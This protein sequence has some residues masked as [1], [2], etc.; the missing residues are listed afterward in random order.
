LASEG[1]RVAI[2]ARIPDGTYG[3]VQQWVIGLAGALSRLPD[4]DEVYLFLVRRGRHDWLDPYLEGRCRALVVADRSSGT[5]RLTRLRRCLA[6]ALPTVAARWRHVRDYIAARRST[7]EVARSDGVI[8]AAGVD[9]VHFTFQD[10]FI[11]D[12]PSLYQPWD[13]Q[14]RHL[15]TFFSAAER[16]RREITYRAFSEQARVV[17]APTTWIK[18]DLVAELE[19]PPGK[20]AVVNV[21]PV[22][23]MYVVPSPED[24][25]RV[26]ERLGLPPRFVFY[27]AQTWPHKNHMRLLGALARLRDEEGLRV[28]LVCS[29]HQN[30]GYRAI[31]REV[32]SLGLASQV[33]FVGFVEPIELQVLYRRARALVF[34]SLYE[35]WGLPVVEAFRA[36]LPVACSDTTSLPALVG[37]AAVVF[38]PLDT[39]DIAAAVRRVWLDDRLVDELAQR[40]RRRVAQL[41]WTVTAR[42]LRALYREVAGRERSAADASLL[43]RTP[44]V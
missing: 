32:R 30:A 39:A 38:D 23:A 22:T 31:E 10:A 6:D 27:P 21:P 25:A 5:H 41:D 42:I 1:L 43:S 19:L 2:D 35:G 17:I 24:S 7:T 15:P 8:E 9:V 3:G 11:T 28:A 18:R 16:Q 29:G 33:R 12:V 20:I 13:L 14:H 37:D 36:G 26:A 4:G 44:M 34:P 40:G